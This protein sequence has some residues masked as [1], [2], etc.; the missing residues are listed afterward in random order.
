MQE[1]EFKRMQWLAC[2]LDAD[3]LQ[4]RHLL[5]AIDLVTHG[6]RVFSKLTGKT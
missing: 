2:F 4:L 6:S 3:E 5:I 1:A